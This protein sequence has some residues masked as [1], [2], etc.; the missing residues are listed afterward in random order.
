MKIITTKFSFSSILSLFLA[1]ILLTSC[2]SD[3]TEMDKDPV[4]EDIL[5]VQTQIEIDYINQGIDD[6]IE[7]TAIELNNSKNSFK[8]INTKN[9]LSIRYLPECATISTNLNGSILNVTIDFGDAC[10]TLKE[11]V[12]SGKI[13]AEITYNDSQKIAIIKQ[14]F[15]NFYF[16]SKKIDGT[17]DRKLIIKNSIGNP[18]V[19][20][21]RDI[22]INWPDASESMVK[23]NSKR[24]C[25]EGNETYGWL[26]NVYLITGSRTVT[27]GSEKTRTATILSPLKKDMTCKFV[28]SG[29]VKFENNFTITLDYGD[30]TCDDLAIATINGKDY[31]IQLKK[32]WVK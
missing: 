11:D 32:N 8:E 30:G 15:D 6:M 9:M 13:I 10:T 31:P 19:E 20:I 5:T 18:E 27:N 17:I 24:E 1:G 22:T 23:E 28:E 4:A 16:N 12:V 29:I 26:D 21:T 3:S 14:S 7:T 2:S 25:I